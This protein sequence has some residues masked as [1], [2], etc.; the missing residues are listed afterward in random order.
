MQMTQEEIRSRYNRA[1]DK[2]AI[3]PILADLNGT[4]ERTIRS[5]VEPQPEPEPEKAE[6][7]RKLLTQ[8]ERAEIIR[9]MLIAGKPVNQ[10]A[11]AA[12][13]SESTVMNHARKLKLEA[14]EADEKEQPAP[15]RVVAVKVARSED[16]RVA[17]ILLAMPADAAKETK[18]L[19]YELCRSML[20]NA[21]K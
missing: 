13:C 19:C 18:L 16:G 8:R 3:V 5:I 10:I 12:G 15:E 9:A 14:V 11:E 6:T 17:D 4:D 1:E 2:K 7:G 20:R 21:A